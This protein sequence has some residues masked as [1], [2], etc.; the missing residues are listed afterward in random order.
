MS[1]EDSDKCP[2][3]VIMVKVVTPYIYVVKDVDDDSIMGAFIYL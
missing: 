3:I 2:Y 1:A